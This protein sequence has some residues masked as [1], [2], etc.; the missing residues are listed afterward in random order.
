VHLLGL[1]VM[2]VLR[3]ALRLGRLPG[4]VSIGVALVVPGVLAEAALVELVAA[5]P[6]ASEP[7]ELALEIEQRFAH[8]P[9]QDFALEL[10]PV[11]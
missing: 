1:E 2:I 4:S 9:A 8:E 10:V 11:L 6:V 7:A 3:L 5:A